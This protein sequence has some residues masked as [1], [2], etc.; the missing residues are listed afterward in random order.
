VAEQLPAVAAG[1]APAPAGDAGAAPLLTSWTRLPPRQTLTI[2]VILAGV[3]AAA[4]GAWLWA[5]QPDSRVLYSTLADRDGG[6]IISSIGPM[7]VP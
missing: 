1:N 6:E 2:G 5:Q 4:V 3:I 7:N